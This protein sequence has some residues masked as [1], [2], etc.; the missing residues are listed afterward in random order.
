[1]R[2]I[3]FNQGLLAVGVI[4]LTLV[5]ADGWVA[6]GTL[7]IGF[8]EPSEGDIW[9]PFTLILQAVALAIPV[10]AIL[11]A[12][13][14][15][16]GG[17]PRPLTNK[18]FLHLVGILGLILVSAKAPFTPIF[19][20]AL[21]PHP[22]TAG[23]FAAQVV[24]FAIPVMAFV[25]RSRT[26]AET[27]PDGPDDSLTLYRLVQGFALLGLSF[28]ASAAPAAFTNI[29]LLDAQSYLAG[30]LLAGPLSSLIVGG[31][32]AAGAVALA[33][34][35]GRASVGTLGSA[36]LLGMTALVAVGA[37]IVAGNLGFSLPTDTALLSVAILV[38]VGLFL[39]NAVATDPADSAAPPPQQGRILVAVGL[40]GMV[41][42]AASMMEVV[43]ATFPLGRG[44]NFWNADAGVTG[45]PMT[46]VAA[47]INLAVIVL[48]VRRL[49]EAS[50]TGG[51]AIPRAPVGSV[52]LVSSAHVRRGVG[53]LGLTVVSAVGLG[54]VTLVWA[55]FETPESRP[56][57]AAPIVLLVVAVA[58]PLVLTQTRALGSLPDGNAN[59]DLPAPLTYSGLLTATGLLGLV[60][61][62]VIA[63]ANALG[64]SI[65]VWDGTTS[66]KWILIG[67]GGAF[68]VP[69]AI[70]VASR[71]K[72]RRAAGSPGDCDDHIDLPRLAMCLA[73]LGAT[74]AASGSPSVVESL[75]TTDAPLSSL[76]SDV[77]VLIQFSAG[78]AALLAACVLLLGNAPR[79]SAWFE[80]VPSLVVAGLLA[81]GVIVVV[82]S[83]GG[84]A[85][86]PVGLVA[87]AVIAL[88]LFQ[89]RDDPLPGTVAITAIWRRAT[90]PLLSLAILMPLTP[91]LAGIV[92]HD[93]TAGLALFTTFTLAFAYVINLWPLALSIFEL[94][95]EA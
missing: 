36:A 89:S 82:P 60:I 91:P 24:A 25:G 39:A 66:T 94:R 26:R 62:T 40:A 38:V 57:V 34:S 12:P 23:V 18:Q 55:I 35:R 15:W 72:A 5:L 16:D 76:A 56:S 37:T 46:G 75:R 65:L 87:L 42:T 78:C 32:M 74:V 81:L 80:S 63:S 64:I 77:G 1:M 43:E 3:T 90:V 9:L 10:G 22:W 54:I 20:Q 21:G 79:A 47:L 69:L 70:I 52:G 83:F 73:L 31:S 2:S 7:R 17:P 58:I 27:G 41:L 68:L 53:L 11:Y 71:L 6:V 4:G 95:R 61:V 51:Q 88:H 33:L 59:P 48:G 29:A 19:M 30:F 67:Q 86:L 92:S 49:R 13:P 50:G 85:F 84:S 14:R 8:G 45:F 44:P 93:P 28:A